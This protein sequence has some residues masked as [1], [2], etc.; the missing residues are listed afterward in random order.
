MGV[1]WFQIRHFEESD[2]LVALSANFAI[3]GDLS[4]RMMSLAACL[5][6]RQVI[7]SIDESFIDL[8]GIRGDT[9]L[10]SRK[11]RQ[12]ILQ[13]I[14][15]TKTLDKLANHIAKTA[16]RKP[17]GYPEHH[18]Q[19]CHLGNLPSDKLQV[20]MQATE[21]G[22]VWVVGRRIG[23]GE[24]VIYTCPKTITLFNSRDVSNRLVS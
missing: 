22:E 14:G 11:I 3:Y 20:L 16:E 6:H 13:W 18:A 7:Y 10:P 19:V 23:C 17:G 5:G 9:T 15:L 24:S 8:T 21:V 12:R 1:P 4:D 2:G